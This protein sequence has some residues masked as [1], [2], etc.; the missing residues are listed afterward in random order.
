M[1]FCLFRYATVATVLLFSAELGHATIA[2]QNYVIDF[3]PS[4]SGQ[5]VN[6]GPGT[7]FFPV[8]APGE[9]EVINDVTL[10]AF[11]VPVSFSETIV[12]PGYNISQDPIY[13]ATFTENEPYTSSVDIVD[14]QVT[15]VAILSTLTSGPLDG[16]TLQLNLNNTWSLSINDPF[17]LAGTYGVLPPSVVPEPGTFGLLAFAAG[18]IG[19]VI[20]RRKA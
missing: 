20:R 9:S 6:L 19:A 11:S 7:F 18:G 4:S 3:S 14:G 8:A 5:L 13:D 15:A 17:T 12:E 10:G 1:K 2:V 16:S